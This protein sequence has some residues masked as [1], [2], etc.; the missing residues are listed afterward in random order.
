MMRALRTAASGMYAQQL[1]IDT[2]SNNLANVSTNG[3]KKSQVE[4]QDLIYQTIQATHSVR[5][6]GTVVPAELQIG[7]GVKAVAIEKSF[8]QGSPMQTDNVLDL[9][10]EGDGFFQ[11]TRPDG[12]T[13]YTRDGNFKQSADGRMVTSDGYLLEPEITFPDDTL[14]VAIDKE[15]YVYATISNRTDAIELGQI[16]L[17]RFTN[18]AGLRSVGQNLYQETEASGVPIIGNPSED[19]FGDINQGYLEG[20]NVDVVEEMVNMIVAQRAYE[21]SSKAIKTTED[22]LYLANN[23]KQ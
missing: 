6:L 23:L 12:S 19:G 22:M 14:E 9:S 10:V 5:N 13:A 8:T 16:E 4:F 18:P 15:G 20:S 17:A 2:I 11:I 1:A 21:I 3:F 7:H